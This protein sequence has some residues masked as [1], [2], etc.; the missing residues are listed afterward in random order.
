M[1]LGNLGTAT[2]NITANMAGYNAALASL[3][4]KFADAEAKLR[5]QMARNRLDL[6]SVLSTG[7]T[8]SGAVGNY[9]QLIAQQQQLQQK[10]QAVAKAA[11]QAAGAINAASQAGQKGV[12]GKGG[13]A[14]KGMPGEKSKGAYRL[15]L[16]GQFLDDLQYVQEMGVRPILNNLMQISPV[17]GIVGIAIDQVVR[18]WGD[19]FGAA[20]KALTPVEQMEAAVKKLESKNPKFGWDLSELDLAKKKLDELKEREETITRLRKGRSKAEEERGASVEEAV[21]QSGGLDKVV[22]GFMGADLQR[23]IDQGATKGMGAKEY[24]SFMEATRQRILDDIIRATKGD[25]KSRNALIYAAGEGG[26]GAAKTFGKKLKDNDPEA[27]RAAEAMDDDFHAAKKA[28][29]EEIAAMD[30]AGSINLGAWKEAKAKRAKDAKEA[31]DLLNP[32]TVMADLLRNNAPV[33]EAGKAN[34]VGSIKQA[35]DGAGFDPEKTARL[36]QDVVD[37]ALKEIDKKVKERL[38]DAVNPVTGGAVAARSSV[39]N[40]L[41]R[42]LK[43]ERKAKLQKEFGKAEIMDTSSFLSRIALAGQNARDPAIETAKQTLDEN[44]KQT[45][46]VQEVAKNTRELNKLRTAR[47]SKKA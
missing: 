38:L 9:S 17:L 11:G 18:H 6:K 19:F 32:K 16:A 46:A 23:S 7:L 30:E 34:Q 35:L 36:A 47:Y 10:L 43:D 39:R 40:Q 24:Q 2:V 26:T 44:K 8:T 37:E 4:S 28:N 13:G 29:E 1:S 22:E 12:G 42:E 15:M 21:A 3:P 45:T 5:A 20:K 27:K 14:G 33:S 41:D 25:A 31:L